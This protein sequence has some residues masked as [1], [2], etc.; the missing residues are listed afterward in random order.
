MKPLALVLVIF[1]LTVSGSAGAAQ[2]CK[3][4]AIKQKLTGDALIS[5]A[6]QCEL[7]VLVA[8]ANQTAGKNDG[9]QM[10]SCAAKALGVGPRWCVP[11]E[12]KDN[13][14]CTGGSG[15]N[16]CWAGLCGK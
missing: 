6:K 12:C 14:D 15:C 7:D 11:D 5:F 9:E 8:C 4:K 13:S 3:S 2:T 1:A 10:D 16:V